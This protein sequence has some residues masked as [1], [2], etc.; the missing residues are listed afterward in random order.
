MWPDYVQDG[1]EGPVLVKTAPCFPGTFTKGVRK[2]VAKL[3]RVKPVW[4]FTLFVLQQEDGFAH[5]TLSA[6]EKADFLLGQVRPDYP[7]LPEVE[8]FVTKSLFDNLD[9][10]GNKHSYPL[11]DSWRSN[12]IKSST[13]SHNLLSAKPYLI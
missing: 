5:F 9:R 6:G 11:P 2:C 1:N 3:F 12:G 13:P 10:I 7:T 8:A 4:L